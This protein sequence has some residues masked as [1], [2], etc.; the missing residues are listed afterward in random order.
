MNAV[1]NSLQSHSYLPSEL[2]EKL[3]RDGYKESE[4]KEAVAQLLH[5][6]EV[7]LSPERRLHILIAA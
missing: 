1:L 2:L 3:L 4:I 5:D 6:Q 7:E